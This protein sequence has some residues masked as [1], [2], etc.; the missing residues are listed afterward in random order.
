MGATKIWV[1]DQS[2]CEGAILSG[3]EVEVIETC[4]GA[5]DF[6]IE[7]FKHSGLWDI[8]VGLYPDLLKKENGKDW[9]ALN[10]V[11]LIKELM[12][13]GRVSGAGKVLSDAHLVVMAG[14]NLEEVKAKESKGKNIM[15]E[16]TLGNHLS[17]IS[18]QTSMKSLYEHVKYIRG[19][20]WIRGKIYA[21]DA[22]EIIVPYGQE[23]EG[24][25]AVGE[26]QGYKIVLLLN[27][28][29]DRE[30][31]VGFALGP[32]QASERGLLKN[33]LDRLE[34]EVAPVKEIIDLLILDRGYWGAEFFKSLKEGYEIDFVTRFR[35]E[36]LDV[37]KDIDGRLKLGEHRWHQRQEARKRLGNIKVK[38]TGIED[39]PLYNEEEELVINVNAV[40]AHEYDETGNPLKDEKGRERA[41]MIYATS[42]ETEKRPYRIRKHCYSKT[43]ERNNNG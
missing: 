11:M 35:D 4:Y 18:V 3:E 20:K 43:N 22:H 5:N 6:V 30:R 8:A 40:I 24:M 17:R 13:I 1:K 29:K 37:V 27:I 42:L 12:K 10:G 36:W 2:R 34:E 38:V 19:R 9:R 7:F 28:E 15:I 21:A 39:L 26:K 16:E 33:I 41:R 32:L 23:Y 14:F 25:G 31:I